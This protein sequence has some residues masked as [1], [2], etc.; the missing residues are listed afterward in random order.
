MR[1]WPKE[2]PFCDMTL[3]SRGEMKHHLAWHV[4]TDQRDLFEYMDILADGSVV[5]KSKPL[6]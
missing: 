2:C 4:Y 3:F 1:D 6:T 5:E